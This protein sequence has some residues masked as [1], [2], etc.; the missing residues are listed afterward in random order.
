MKYRKRPIVIEATQWLQAGDHPDVRPFERKGRDPDDLHFDGC[1]QPWKDHG[2]V[3]TLEGGFIVCPTDFIVTGVRGER[4][5]CKAHIFH[6][7]Y[8]TL[9]A[10]DDE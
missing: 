4:Y 10:S 9:E 8:E 3:D 6:Q 7:T 1:G 5:P 2:W